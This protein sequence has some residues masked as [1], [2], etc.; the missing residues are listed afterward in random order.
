[1]GGPRVG[2]SRA[3]APHRTDQ[4]QFQVTTGNPNFLVVGVPRPRGRSG[5]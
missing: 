5:N 2:V 1:M 4:V 3:P